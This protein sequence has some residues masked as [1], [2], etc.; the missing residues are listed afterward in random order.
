MINF[1][2]LIFELIALII[3]SIFVFLF[4]VFDEIINRIRKKRR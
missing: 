3:V 4:I 1:F 2:K